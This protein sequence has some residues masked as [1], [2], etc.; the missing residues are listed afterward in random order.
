MEAQI[1]GELAD[2]QMEGNISLESAPPL[3]FTGSKE[4]E[5]ESPE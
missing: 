5:T 4:A 1:A 3:P 2:K